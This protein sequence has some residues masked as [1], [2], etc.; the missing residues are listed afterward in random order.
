MNSLKIARELNSLLD[1]LLV[2][3]RFMKL[4]FLYSIFWS[5]SPDRKKLLHEAER[6]REKWHDDTMTQ[7]SILQYCGAQIAGECK[8]KRDRGNDERGRK[9]LRK[10]Y[11]RHKLSE[12]KIKINIRK[13]FCVYP[14][15]RNKAFLDRHQTSASREL[16]PCRAQKN[17]VNWRQFVYQNR[18]T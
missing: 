3:W 10:R 15:R 14:K 4:D 6:E 16:L 17:I 9:E 13:K 2:R 18:A 1:I 8:K 7:S 12:P 5:S 11:K